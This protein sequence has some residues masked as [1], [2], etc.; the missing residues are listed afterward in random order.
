MKTISC[1]LNEYCP[2]EVIQSGRDVIL[3]VVVDHVCI[4]TC[5]QVKLCSRAGLAEG[6]NGLGFLNAVTPVGIIRMTPY[7]SCCMQKL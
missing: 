3:F 7:L 2:S 6:C 5:V 1:F 4:L